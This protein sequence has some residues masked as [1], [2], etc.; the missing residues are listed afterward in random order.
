MEINISYFLDKVYDVIKMIFPAERFGNLR[1]K[2]TI[3][4]FKSFFH[5]ILISFFPLNQKLWKNSLQPPLPKTKL[6][7]RDILK[8][9]KK[10][11]IYE[12]VA[13]DN[14]V[15]KIFCKIFLINVLFSI[16]NYKFIITYQILAEFLILKMIIKWGENNDYELKNVSK[17]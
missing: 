6:F 13:I 9:S 3:R 5:I 2:F 15:I 17:E 1:E 4:I 10:N 8:V 16:K 14:I 7:C 11:D 12:Y